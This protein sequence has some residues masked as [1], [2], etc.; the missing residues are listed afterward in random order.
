MYGVEMWMFQGEFLESAMERGMWEGELYA[1]SSG[2]KP[3]SG[4]S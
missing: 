2:I 3:C 4:K 1:A